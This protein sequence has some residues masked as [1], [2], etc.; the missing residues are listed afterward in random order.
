MKK[1]HLI[2]GFAAAMAFAA[3]ANAGIWSE[4]G[5]AGDLPGTAQTA[6][7]AGSLDQIDGALAGG[8]DM[9]RICITSPSTFSADT[10]GGASFDTQLFLFDLNGV[11]VLANDDSGTLQARLPAGSFTLAAGEYYLAISGFDR[12]PVD[13]G[14]NLIFPTFPFGGVY[15]PIDGDS[16]AGWAGGSG[17]G[18]YSIFLTGA[19][20]CNPVPE[21]TGVL[22]GLLGLAGLH[23]ARRRVG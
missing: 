1:W 4:V 23:S 3:S 6:V 18:Q 11:G 19:A 17:G 16:I 5:D 2:S 12:D 10:N 22:L 15:G 21:P 9:Y 7:G 14:G 13:A 20:F 8:A